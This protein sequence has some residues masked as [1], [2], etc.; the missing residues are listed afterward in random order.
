[1][2]DDEDQ[3]RRQKE[4]MQDKKKGIYQQKKDMTEELTKKL[5]VLQK[6]H[7]QEELDQWEKGQDN[8]PS[9]TPLET[10]TRRIRERYDFRE[11]DVL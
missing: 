11:E 5:G 10:I 6:K 2:A 8:I 3:M 9:R 1:M 4:L 7:I